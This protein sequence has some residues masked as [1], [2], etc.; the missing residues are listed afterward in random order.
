MGIIVFSEFTVIRI[1]HLS[2]HLLSSC[3]F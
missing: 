3:G 1:G 2:Q